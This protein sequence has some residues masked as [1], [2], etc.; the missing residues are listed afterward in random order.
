MLN[1]TI[2]QLI[3]YRD[4]VGCYGYKIL[5]ILIYL[6]TPYP[7]YGSGYF[8]LHMLQLRQFGAKPNVV[9]PLAF[10]LCLKEHQ[11]NPLGVGPCSYGNSTVVPSESGYI[12]QSEDFS[13]NVS[14][15]VNFD[16][17]WPVRT[18]CGVI[19]DVIV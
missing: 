11:V 16:Y 18:S 5:C 8:K 3:G 14:I 12:S 7:V 4:I 6:I 1:V 15:T 2:M 9:C 10:H 13:E 19:T 17:S